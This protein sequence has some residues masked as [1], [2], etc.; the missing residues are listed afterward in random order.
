LSHYGIA[1]RVI[2]LYS[3]KP[4]D[5]DTLLAAVSDTQGHLVL[6]EDHHPEGGLGSAVRD[7]LGEA[8]SPSY[9]MTHLAV[10][11]MPGSGEP[12]E[13]LAAAGIDAAAIAEAAGRLLD[14]PVDHVGAP[15]TPADG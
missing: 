5:V 4:I 11:I 1:A 7:A 13:L 8:G 6:A 12:A 9:Q 3:V 2:D 10:R 15:P 14:S